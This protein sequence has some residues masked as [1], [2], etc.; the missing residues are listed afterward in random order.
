MGASVLSA[1]IPRKEG[2]IETLYAAPPKGSLVVNL[3][4]MGPEAAKSFAGQELV[5]P[6]PTSGPAE[7]A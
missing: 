4:Q 5:R 2:S 7:R 3:D 1:V 6:V